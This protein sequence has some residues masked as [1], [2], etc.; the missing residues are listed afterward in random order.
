MPVFKIRENIFSIGVLNPG[1]RV[2]DIIMRTDFGTSY[3]AF[4]V[5][6]ADRT[7][8]IDTVHERFADEYFANLDEL[9]GSRRPDALIIQHCEP[10]HTGTVEQLLRRYPG[11]E[12]LTTQAGAVNIKKITNDPSINLR[13]VADGETYDLGGERLRFISAPF[14]HWPDT[15]FTYDA[16]RRVVF[17][18]DFLGCHY[19]EPA[20]YDAAIKYPGAYEEAF[21]N[22]YIGVL[23]PFKKYVIAGLDKLDALDFDAVCPSHGPVLTGGRIAAAGAKYREWSAPAPVE[24]K[25]S[26]CVFY[27]S[28]YGYTKMLAERIADGIKESA[29]YG[30]E[31]YDLNETPP[32]HAAARINECGAFLIGSPTLNRDAVGPIWALLASIDGINSR[33]RPCAAF[34]SFGWSGEAVPNIEARLAGLKCKVFS[35]NLK[36]QFRPSGAELEAAEKFGQDFAAWLGEGK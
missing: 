34:G 36:V 32:Q 17:T 13:V 31:L 28:A 29:Q 18:C 21:H 23:S 12:V 35:Q 9:L 16:A 5:S 11:I 26:V 27:C 7:V 4:A 3:N 14:L 25:S 10:D 24:A 30:V 1:M 2:F 15:M 20:V 19:C 8:L 22:Y 6:G 33:N